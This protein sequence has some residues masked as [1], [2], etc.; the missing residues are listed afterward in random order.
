MKKEPEFLC[1]LRFVL[2]THSNGDGRKLQYFIT[3]C[4]YI[5]LLLQY[6]VFIV[7]SVF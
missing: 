7:Q 4:C 2:L 5:F 3:K 6:K 1:L